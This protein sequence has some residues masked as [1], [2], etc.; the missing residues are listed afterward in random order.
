MASSAADVRVLVIDDHESMRRILSMLLRAYG[1]P[2]I[3]EAENGRHALSLI[4]DFDPDIVVTDFS[5]PL[6]DGITFARELRQFSNPRIA[7]LPVV[8]VSGHAH[9]AH[10]LHARDAG[11][12]E[13]ISKPITGRSLA[14]RIRRIIVE[15]RVFVRNEA[16][17]G[18]CR[19]RGKPD[20]AGPFRRA[21]DQERAA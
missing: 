5:M 21:E 4:E 6:M 10:V 1:F 13:F 19:R 8:M 20:Y 15:D 11:V 2:T 12:N 9:H 17:A 14:E 18:P 7:M 3:R 16:Y